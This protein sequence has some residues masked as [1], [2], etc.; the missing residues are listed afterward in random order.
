MSF[1]VQDVLR[2]S[3][4]ITLLQTTHASQNR[5]AQTGTVFRDFFIFLVGRKKKKKKKY[6]FKKKN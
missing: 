3:S 2:I 1:S 6:K 5:P 4:N